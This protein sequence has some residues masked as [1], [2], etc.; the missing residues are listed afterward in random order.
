MRRAIDERPRLAIATTAAVAVFVVAIILITSS[1]SGASTK[2]SRAR[3]AEH[4]TAAETAAVQRLQ[5][6]L[7]NARNALAAATQRANA[8]R[9]LAD[10]HLARARAWKAAPNMAAELCHKQENDRGQRR[11]R[12]EQL[13]GTPGNDASASREQAHPSRRERSPQPDH[14]RGT[15][16][17]EHMRAVAQRDTPRSKDD[18]GHGAAKQRGACGKDRAGGERVGHTTVAGHQREGHQRQTQDCSGA[19]EEQTA[20]LKTRAAMH[21]RTHLVNVGQTRAPHR[22]PNGDRGEKRIGTGHMRGRKADGG[23]NQLMGRVAHTRTL[24]RPAVGSV[25]QSGA[26][27]SRRAHLPLRRGPVATG[28]DIA[29]HVTDARRIAQSGEPATGTR[30]WQGPM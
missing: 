5:G 8:N 15:R 22:G 14:R 3:R 18:E 13:P 27:R 21:P 2:H 11:H 4:R 24:G 9:R 1:L 17:G 23:A 10:A 30:L 20:A 16:V 29:G 6:Q 7:T 19:T 25:V 26:D 12:D 28:D